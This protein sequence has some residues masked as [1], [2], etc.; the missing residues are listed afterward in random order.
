MKITANTNKNKKPK[1]KKS[2]NV[3]KESNDLFIID[4]DSTPEKKK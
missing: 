1:K 4:V 2:T 3:Q